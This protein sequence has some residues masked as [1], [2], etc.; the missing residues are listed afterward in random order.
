M[1][2]YLRHEGHDISGEDICPL[3]IFQKMIQTRLISPSKLS[4]LTEMMKFCSRKDL[5]QRIDEFNSNRLKGNVCFCFFL[6]SFCSLLLPFPFQDAQ[7][8]NQ[9]RTLIEPLLIKVRMTSNLSISSVTTDQDDFVFVFFTINS[10][11]GAT[12][13]LS[14]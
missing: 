7:S 2:K 12:K 4:E 5:M 3:D 9:T 8:F 1:K 13:K 6:G 10:E 14:L 11:I